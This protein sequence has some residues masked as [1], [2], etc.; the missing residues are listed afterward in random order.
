M[1]YLDMDGVLADFDKAAGRMLD[2]DNIYKFE[3]QHGTAEFW[4]GINQ[5]PEFWLNIPVMPD[6]MELM[7]PIWDAPKAVLTIAPPAHYQP[8]EMA[9]RQKTR[10]VAENILSDIPVH[11]LGGVYTVSGKERFC[12]EGD[13]LIDDRAKFGKAWGEAG[14]IFIH[15]TSAKETVRKLRDLGVI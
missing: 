5:D 1:I 11:V 10:W 3:F 13:V 15:H 2:T 9:K 6:M 4:H 12:R 8:Y 14:G 7:H